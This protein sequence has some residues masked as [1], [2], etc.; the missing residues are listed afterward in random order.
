[1]IVKDR[2]NKI[3]KNTSSSNLQKFLYNTIIGRFIL[4][5]LTLRF[6]SK[7]V[8]LFLNSHLSKIFI[9]KF[10]KDNNIDLTN[11]EKNKFKSYNDFFTRKLKNIN[12]DTNPNILI[13]PCDSK[14][15]IKKI[16]KNSYYNIKDT[17]YRILDIL[18]NNDLANEFN[19]GYILVFRLEVTDY[20]RYHYIDNGY[21][22]EKKE[23]KGRL[24]TVNPIAFRKY[25][26]YKENSRVIN[27]LKTNNFGKIIQIEVGALCVGKINN[28]NLSNFNK[29]DEKGYF[30]YGGSTVIILIKGNIVNFDNDILIN[31]NKNIETIVKVGERIGKKIN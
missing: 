13:S 2:N 20:H 18:K 17:H 1:M 31:S 6:I 9:K 26:V 22:L 15:L 29:G 28:N 21:L 3:I 11:C 4:K 24:H 16:N 25:N 7:L 5:L 12:Y 30:L 27:V 10:V 14:L 8:G 23:I 19:N